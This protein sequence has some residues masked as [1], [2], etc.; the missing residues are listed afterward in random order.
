M[1]YPQFVKKDFK[2]TVLHTFNLYKGTALRDPSFLEFFF[3][4]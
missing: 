2:V 4:N 1:F 3:K